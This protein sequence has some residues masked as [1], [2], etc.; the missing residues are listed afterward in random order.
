MWVE[1]KGSSNQKTLIP[2]GF[3]N[4]FLFNAKMKLLLSLINWHKFPIH[5]IWKYLTSCLC[6]T[7]TAKHNPK[8]FLY[9]WF[10]KYISGCS[11]DVPVK[12]NLL[13]IQFNQI[14]LITVWIS[15]IKVGYVLRVTYIMKLSWLWDMGWIDL[16]HTKCSTNLFLLSLT[17]L[18]FVVVC[19][20]VCCFIN[21]PVIIIFLFF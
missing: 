1:T 20:F 4:F 7:K 9:K 11:S 5:F 15:G 2:F 6:Q 3:E 14:C 17:A 18:W 13:S 19:M 16:V 12:K 21:H 8:Y 10:Y